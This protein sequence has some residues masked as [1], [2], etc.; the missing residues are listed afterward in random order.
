MNVIKRED[1]IS[2]APISIPREAETIGCGG[3]RVSK[4]GVWRA[5]VLIGVHVLIIAH[6]VHWKLAG[7]TVS[8]VEP[9]EAM[10]TLELGYVNAGFILFIG[11]I[12]S[13][14]VF[15]R[16][17]CGWGC[18][19]VALQDVCGW[20]MKKAGVKPK[21][22][23]SRLLVFVPLFAAFYMFLWPTIVRWLDGRAFPGLSNHLQTE[24]FWATFPGPGIALLTFGICGFLIVYLLG[25]KGFCTYGCPYGAIFYHADRVAPGKIRVTDA[26]EGCGHCTA[27]CT[28]NVRVHE[29]VKRYGMVVDPGCMKCMDCVSVCPK[30]A[31]YYGFGKPSLAQKGIEAKRAPGLERAA[32]MYDF[33]LSE[34]IAM[35]A[36]FALAFYAFR[37]LYDSVPFLL[38]IGLSSVTAFLIVM[39][40]RLLYTPSFRLQHKQLRISGATTPAG[41]ALLGVAG[42]LIVFAGHSGV[43]QFHYHEG[44]RLYAQAESA[45]SPESAEESTKA[46][47]EHF[48]W[49]RSSGFFPV[50]NLEASLGSGFAFLGDLEKGEQH[51]RRAIELGPDLAGARYQ[52]ARTLAARGKQNEA[53]AQLRTAVE[54]DPGRVA[55]RRDLALALSASGKHV[56]ALRFFEGPLKIAPRDADLRL[57]YAASLAESGKPAEAETQLR[58]V[59]TDHPQSAQ[60]R[61][62]LGEILLRRGKTSEAAAAFADAT[63]LNPEAI[64]SYVALARL[65]SRRKNHSASARRYEA[66][67]GIAPFDR[68]LLNAWAVELKKSN[69]IDAAIKKLVRSHPDDEASWYR[70][71]LLYK[72][73]GNLITAKSLYRR[74]AMRNPNLPPL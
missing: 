70:A 63:R 34:E 22:F 28:S 16:F 69:Q 31:L 1:L 35:A 47:M 15:G 50:A 74:L 2:A 25:N 33:S 30:N 56:E 29:E 32:R 59:M 72:A 55:A 18:H 67:L 7:K 65:D 51:L 24:N 14:L 13:T 66:A 6:I 46:A 38:A 27:T 36:L 43:W 57:A 37:G 20:L 5:A 17:F 3:L 49:C 54:S 45:K 39:A 26:C 10:Q 48:G 11:L 12:L 41:C 21:P 9:S 64:E 52:L 8:P 19:V 60:V 61:F 44:N 68:N 40:A 62:A 4:R 23:R 71:A 58:K 73:K 42:L 53:I